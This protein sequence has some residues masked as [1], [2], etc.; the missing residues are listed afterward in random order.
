[1]LRFE[2]KTSTPSPRLVECKDAARTFQ[3][4]ARAVDGA[5]AAAP[6]NAA[7]ALKRRRLSA[8]TTWLLRASI[9]TRWLLYAA[10]LASSR[11]AR[12]ALAAMFDCDAWRLAAAACRYWPG[13]DTY[14]SQARNNVFKAAKSKQN[15]TRAGASG[16]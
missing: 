10:A 6:I 2:S 5:T 16:V 3:V 7:A 1:M 14:N 8:A 11:N 13:S 15:S 9:G 4:I 12:A